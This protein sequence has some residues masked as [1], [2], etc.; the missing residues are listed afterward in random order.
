MAYDECRTFNRKSY[1]TLPLQLPPAPPARLPAAVLQIYRLI[2]CRLGGAL[3]V[4]RRWWS[5]LHGCYGLPLARHVSA[6]CSG[7]LGVQARRCYMAAAFLPV[8]GLSISKDIATVEVH[9]ELFHQS[10]MV[11]Y[12]YLAQ[13]VFPLTVLTKLTVGCG[14]SQ[15]RCPVL[16][17]V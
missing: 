14:L 4:V 1:Q 15:P 6:Q 17:V 16:P 13:L 7:V 10:F 11:M 12:S 5:Q 3:L 9:S 2:I 8:P